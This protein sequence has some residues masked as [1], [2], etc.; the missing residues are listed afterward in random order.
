MANKKQKGSLRKLLTVILTI[1]L[2]VNM[3]A[4]V[5]TARDYGNNRPGSNRPDYNGENDSFEHIEINVNGAPAHTVKG[6]NGDF[7]WLVAGVYETPSLNMKGNVLSYVV[8]NQKGTYTVSLPEGYT[9]AEST[10]TSSYGG[11]T[12]TQQDKFDHAIINITIT[13]VETPDGD[14]IDVPEI[15]E[16]P[17]DIVTTEEE[18]TE[19]ETTEEETTEEETTEEETTEEETTEEETTEEETTEEETTEE[20]TTEEE[21]TEEETTEEETTEEETTEEETTEEE[22]T[23]E[24]TTEEE[25]TEEE[26]TEEET[27]EEET[28]EEE[29]TEEVTTEEVTTEEETTVP[30]WPP[31]ETDPVVPVYPPYNPPYNPPVS[32]TPDDVE[33]I[34]DEDVPLDSTP[35]EVDDSVEVSVEESDEELEEIEDE[36]VPLSDVPQTGSASFIFLAMAVASAIGLIG[37]NASKQEKKNR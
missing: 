33:E 3:S 30:Y 6:P 29:T 14:I 10:L 35:E 20:V 5:I 18:T 36:E 21:T 28:T 32:E 25:T 2:I 13:K 9:V 15:V 34:D 16:D 24:E 12:N 37:V 26:T 7:S 4:L 22:T 17:E 19:E 23:E 1:A 11:G 27:T 8:G 31:V